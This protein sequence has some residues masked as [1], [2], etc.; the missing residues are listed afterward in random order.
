LY[1]VALR[2]GY[3]ELAKLKDGVGYATV[4]A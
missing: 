4:L 2:A 3:A 1:V